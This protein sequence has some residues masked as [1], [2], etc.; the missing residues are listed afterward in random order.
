MKVLQ[1]LDSFSFGGAEA[2]MVELA[3]HAPAELDLGV[4]S[5]AP[6]SQGR[7][8]VLDRFESLGLEPTFFAV[9]RLVDPRGVLDMARRLRAMDVDVVHAHLEYAAT[10]VPLAA[11]MA[12]LPVVATLHHDPQELS[13]SWALR[14]RLAVRIPA[15]TGRLVFVSNPAME[16]FRQRYGGD[17]RHWRMVHNGVDLD[18]YAPRAGAPRPLGLPADAPVWVKVAALREPKGHLDAVAAWREV[19]RS[20]PDAHLVFAGDGPQRPAIEAAVRAAGLTDRVHLAGRVEDV[21]TLL[22]GADGVLSAS[23]TEALPTA[24][25]EA[26]AAELPVVATDVGGTRD[27]IVDGRTGRLVAAHRPAELAAA[28]LEL[29]EN[30]DQA[31][32]FARAAREHAHSSFSMPAWVDNLLALYREVMT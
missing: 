32:R 10:L 6:R 19:V 17:T 2:L 12:G 22:A 8:A 13:W 4:A 29:M 25:I 21:P 11:R 7:N 15:A 1:V 16:S 23:H 24:L 27:V 9:N 5:L 31:A 30:S 18:R 3:R 14:E 28:V 26:C 20:H